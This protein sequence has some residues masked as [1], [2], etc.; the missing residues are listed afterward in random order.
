MP[1]W[2]RDGVLARTDLR[3]LLDE[4]SGPS[5]GHGVGARW[6]CPDPNHD[7]HH[8]SVT[9]TEDRRGIPKWRCWSGG[10]GG[11][12]IDLVIAVY[13]VG[14]EEAVAE[15]ARRAGIRPDEP[16]LRLVRPPLPPQEPVPL[17]NH[18]RRYVEICEE[19]LWKPAGRPV[20]DYL[21]HERGLTAA[22]LRANRVGAD[23]GDRLR[24]PVGLPR[25]GVG[26]VLPAIDADGQV[27]YAQTR[28]L[29]PPADRSKYDNPARRLGDNPRHGW[30]R[31]AGTPVEPVVVCEGLIDAYTMN[32]TGYEA[33]AVL[34]ALNA[35][36]ELADRI[37]TKL[38]TRP[39]IVAFD[40]DDAGRRGAQVVSETLRRR[41][42]MTAEL[43]LPD[44]VDLN[45]WAL[46]ARQV[47]QFD[48]PQRP[49]PSATRPVVTVPTLDGP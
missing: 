34:G 14:F 21:L 20:L 6:R 47:P 36:V 15:L 17:H 41:G 48:S 26:A 31:P 25:G 23:P 49:S 28:Y 30:T 18:V 35:T 9:V 32:A 5:T 22:V 11:S 2:D 39:V 7:D 13:R 29:R 27:V 46:S 45:S 37:A 12:A 44:Q 19:L 38:G 4:M 40:G 8:P 33:V 43:P 16:H 3:A 10:H 1:R 42:I 24:K